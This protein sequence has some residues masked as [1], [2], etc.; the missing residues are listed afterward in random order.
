ML[1]GGLHAWSGWH[2]LGSG[3]H[4]A[5]RRGPRDPTDSHGQLPLPRINPGEITATRP[6][7]GHQALLVLKVPLPLTSASKPP[8]RPADT[9]GALPGHRGS[10]ATLSVS[11]LWSLGCSP[12]SPAPSG[13]PG[14][15]SREQG[16]RGRH[17][18]GPIVDKE[19]GPGERGQQPQ[20]VGS[21]FL[22][23]FALHLLR[24]ADD[25]CLPLK[26]HLAPTN[27]AEDLGP[28]HVGVLVALEDDRRR[29]VAVCWGQP[30]GPSDPSLPHTRP[31]P[32]PAPC[33]HRVTLSA[34]GPLARGAV[35]HSHTS[36][37]K[38]P[39]SCK[40]RG[41]HLCFRF[42]LIFPSCSLLGPHVRHAGFPG[43]RLNGSPSSQADSRAGF[44]F[45]F[46]FKGHTH[47]MWNH[48]GFL[49]R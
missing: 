43:Q 35:S 34:P 49:T 31:W 23:E 27:F 22:D 2:S 5:G 12:E 6:T 47:G 18:R 38:R 10:P 4:R 28:P 32:P 29:P 19:P 40:A 7:A 41:L 30:R 21:V 26:C 20:V 37:P 39:G 13:R 1:G 16:G 3:Q 9:W 25:F 46:N 17:S 8:A 11:H 15:A 48:V 33:Q 36:N 42:P 45:F 14:P 24:G 44:F